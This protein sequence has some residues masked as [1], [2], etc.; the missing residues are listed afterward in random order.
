MGHCKGNLFP[1]CLYILSS[2]LAVPWSPGQEYAALRKYGVGILAQLFDKG[3]L[4]QKLD[5]LSHGVLF[6]GS[7]D[8]ETTHD[9]ITEN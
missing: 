6:A 8:H 5:L 9:R 1:T 3:R 4:E 2:I 7:E